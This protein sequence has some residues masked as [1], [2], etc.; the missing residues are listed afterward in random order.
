[1]VGARQRR[2]TQ[3]P[4]CLPI[5]FKTQQG[6]GLGITYHEAELV[7]MPDPRN[8]PKRRRLRRSPRHVHNVGRISQSYYRA[9]RSFDSPGGFPFRRVPV[10]LD[11]SRRSRGVLSL[12]EHWSWK[13]LPIGLSSVPRC[14]AWVAVRE[15]GSCQTRWRS[16]KNPIMSVIATA[17]EP[18][19]PP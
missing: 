15:D 5:A 4:P 11:R 9:I 8:T 17:F 1:M 18:T 2:V 14:Y 7:A 12:A 6:L 3:G 13:K 16:W 19:N 10:G